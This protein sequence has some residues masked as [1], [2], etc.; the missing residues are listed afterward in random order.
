MSEPKNPVL[1]G[2]CQCGAIRYALTVPPERVHLCHCRMCQ[3]AVGGPFAALAPVKRS[4]FA[5]TRGTPDSFASS[6]LAHR[7]FCARCGTPLS[8]RYDDA[9][10]IAVTLGSLDRPRDVPPGSPL[11]AR[12]PHWLARQHRLTASRDNTGLYVDRKGAKI[13]ELPTPRPRYFCRL[14]AP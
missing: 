1:T 9:D 14:V 5:W 11:R 8:F 6:S 3:K 7:D 2:G 13:R 10:T 12:R 4:G